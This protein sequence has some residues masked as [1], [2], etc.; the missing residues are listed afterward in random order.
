MRP[1]RIY[2]VVVYMT[3]Q[4][5]LFAVWVAG[6]SPVLCFVV[7]AVL[8]QRVVKLRRTRPSVLSNTMQV[9]LYLVAVAYLMVGLLLGRAGL[10]PYV[11]FVLLVAV[12][13][14]LGH[15]KRGGSM[16]ALLC[17]LLVILL[18]QN[19]GHHYTQHAIALLFALPLLVLQLLA[20]CIVESQ[21]KQFMSGVRN[22]M[23]HGVGGTRSERQTARLDHS[24][25]AM[26]AQVLGAFLV[27]VG[28]IHLAL[29][30][31]ESPQEGVAQPID[32]S[33]KTTF[34][35]QRHG[36]QKLPFQMDVSSFSDPAPNKFVASV[37]LRKNGQRYR[38]KGVDL[39]WKLVTYD[40]FD[41]RIWGVERDYRQLSDGMDGKQDQQVTLLASPPGEPV[42]QIVRVVQLQP[43]GLLVLDRPTSVDR[44][45]VWVSKG[46]ALFDFAE[47]AVSGRLREIRARSHL[48]PLRPLPGERARHSDKR[49]TAL[50]ARYAKVLELARRQTR[51]LGSDSA[52][53]R[54]VTS[55]LRQNYMYSRKF[56]D[57][58]GDPVS[59]FLFVTR[60]GHCELFASAMVV[61]LRSI[62][63]PSRVVG[64]F[65]G[66][67]WEELGAYYLIRRRDMHA[68]VEVYFEQTG[69][70]RF[71]PT[72]AAAAVRAALSAQKLEASTKEV[73]EVL[74]ESESQQWGWVRRMLLMDSETRSK[75]LEYLPTLAGFALLL[76][77]LTLLAGVWSF[78]RWWERRPGWG[79]RSG[80]NG[81]EPLPAP[82]VPFYLRTLDVLGR[83]GLVREASETT[84]ELGR[85][86]FARSVAAAEIYDQ[87]AGHYQQVRFGGRRLEQAEQAGLE[88][89]VDQMAF[90]LN[91]HS[92]Q[93]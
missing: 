35:D 84:R 90:E 17:Q 72:P 71:D 25:T 29:P 32:S 34:K 37:R 42:R 9:G 7:S 48:L 51:G 75:F 16:F 91:G 18:L 24:F 41:G 92:D 77:G 69:W 55:Y 14:H 62:G 74:G 61:M 45:L 26:S 76:G 36:R 19:V 56:S 6:T 79:G 89:L 22:R 60:E 85:R 33:P 68:W 49:Y 66:G 80:R 67:T 13:C 52:R 28:V 86:V 23:S 47:G 38:A 30:R 64:G 82:E 65:M 44:D 2:L 50:P 58:G 3:L 57:P 40:R 81:S 83:V 20:L 78:A 8:L 27:V 31:P 53:V 1:Q 4:L 46:G 73:G 87:L 59:G 88:S 5:L 12:V 11:E 70:V 93:G 21:Y 43:P 10:M 54:A 63:M 15:G 39:Y